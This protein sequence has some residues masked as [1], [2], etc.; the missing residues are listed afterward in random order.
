MHYFHYKMDDT[1]SLVDYRVIMD[2]LW[3]FKK[4]KK[5]A[6]SPYFPLG[7]LLSLSLFSFL[8]GLWVL[9]SLME[10][11]SSNFEASMEDKDVNS[12][13]HDDF[14]YICQMALLYPCCICCYYAPSLVW[15]WFHSTWW[16]S[17]E[18]CHE[19][20]MELYSLKMGFCIESYLNPCFSFFLIGNIRKMPSFLN[21]KLN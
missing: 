20:L 19:T 18:V 10:E 6:W 15:W 8:D 14:S 13:F 7:F 5:R 1:C 17:L 16:L 11:G 4:K 2:S 21:C 3:L 12:S 9:L